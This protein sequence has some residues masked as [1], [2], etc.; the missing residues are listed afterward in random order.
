MTSLDAGVIIIAII[1]VIRGIWV[2]LVR[3]LAS[4]AALFLGFITAGKYYKQFSDILSPFIE[5]P[6]IGFLITYGVLFLL[7]F[8]SVV[9]LGF[10]LKKVM[11]VS[12]LGWFDRMMGG[13]FGLC[14]SAIVITVLFMVL[15]SMLASSNP[16]L[17]ESFFAPY[18]KHASTYLLR[19][20]KDQDLQKHFLPKEPAISPLLSLTIPASKT[21]R[22]DPTQKPQ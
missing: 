16:I 14:K 2:G 6:Q 13:L 10:L 9:L 3:Q 19:L 7:V 22:G 21:K 8:L 18:L 17:T 5:T 4:I 15:S 12:L 1:L 11:T 20:I